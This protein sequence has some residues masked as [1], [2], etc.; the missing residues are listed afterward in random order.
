MTSALEVGAKDPARA[1]RLARALSRP[2]AVEAFREQRLRAHVVLAHGARDAKLCVEALDAAAP[3][4]MD[5]TLYETRVLCY[6]ATKDPRLADAE[7]DLGLLLSF[8]R[9]FGADIER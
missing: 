9:P 2:F 7:V 1:G 8:S 5:R 4:P 6:R 3:L